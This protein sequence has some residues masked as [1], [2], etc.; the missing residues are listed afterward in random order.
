[1]LKVSPNPARDFIVVD[2]NT[3]GKKGEILLTVTDMKGYTVHSEAFASGRDQVVVHTTGW[4]KGTYVASLTVNG[5]PVA[6][7]KVTVQ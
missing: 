1:M 6:T 3:D 2:Y 4:E 7:S 5:K